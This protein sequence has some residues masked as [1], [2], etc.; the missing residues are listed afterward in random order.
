VRKAIKT[1]GS[2]PND[3]AVYT[4]VFLALQKARKKWIMPIKE[5][6]LALN[7]FCIFFPNMV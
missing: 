1:N 4:I 5:W 6:Q 3:Y 7:Q 2:F